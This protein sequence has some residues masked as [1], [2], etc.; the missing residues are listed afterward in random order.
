MSGTSKGSFFIRI[1]KVA[2]PFVKLID[3]QQHI[4]SGFI[5]VNVFMYIYVCMYRSLLITLA[6]NENN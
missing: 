2:L 1:T 3:I 5:I 4:W 6:I